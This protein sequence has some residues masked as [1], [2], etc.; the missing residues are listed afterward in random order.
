MTRGLGAQ[1]AERGSLTCGPERPLPPA[2]AYTAIIPGAV[3]PKQI[4]LSQLDAD[5]ERGWWGYYPPTGQK[6]SLHEWEKRGPWTPM[7]RAAQ[8]GD[9]LV[10][11]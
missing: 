6:I 5:S 3:G 9:M 11:V 10:A 7:S 8:E 4:T 1:P 2:I